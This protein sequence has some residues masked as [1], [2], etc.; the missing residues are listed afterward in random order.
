ME[1][2]MPCSEQVQGSWCTSIKI[3]GI[4]QGEEEQLIHK[5][6]DALLFAWKTQ[7]STVMYLITEY[8]KY[9]QQIKMDRTTS[10]LSS[11]AIN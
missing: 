11:Q 9:E 1:E 5:E 3:G 6:K 2:S 7:N 8:Q 10:N 4:L